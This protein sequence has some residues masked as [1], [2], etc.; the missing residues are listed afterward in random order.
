MTREQINE[1]RAQ[2]NG[3]KQGQASHPRKLN[4]LRQRVEYLED[5]VLALSQPSP[6]WYTRLGRW[7]RDLLK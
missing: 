2:W 4:N 6:P 7:L 5:L 3:R 1:K